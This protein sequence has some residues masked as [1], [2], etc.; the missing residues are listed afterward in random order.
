MTP[1]LR[2]SARWFSQHGSAPMGNGLSPLRVN[3]SIR[4]KAR[5][6]PTVPVYLRPKS[7]FAFGVQRAANLSR[8]I[9]RKVTCP[10]TR[11]SVRTAKSFS[12]HR[13]KIRTYGMQTV[14]YTHLRAH[15]TP[16]H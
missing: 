8:S 3:L 15:E 5:L 16:G 14:S 10:A 6:S 12:Q 9:L 7:P 13:G 4:Q 2:T 1:Q 11:S